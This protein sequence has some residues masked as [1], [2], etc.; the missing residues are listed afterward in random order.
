MKSAKITKIEII[1]IEIKLNEP[2]VI[3]K[4]A[5]THARNTV[6]KIYSDTGHYG[7]GECCPYRSIHGETQTGT[8]AFAKELAK[9]LIG[10]NPR[11]IHRH[12]ALMDKL[13]VGNASVKCAFDMALYDLVS[14]MDELPLYAFLK[15]DRDKKIYTDNT[16]SLLSKEKMV[17]KA[18]KF[19]EMGFPVLKV[20][21]GERGVTKDVERMQ[22]IRAA[23]GDELPLRID[24]NQGW[25]YLDAKRTVEAMKDLNIEHCEEPVL[26]GNTVDQVRLTAESPIPIMA[27]ESVFNHKDAYKILSQQAAHLINIKLGKS[28]GICNAMKIAAIAQAADVYCQTGSFSESRLGISALVHFDMAWDNIIFHDLDSPLMLSE[29]PVMGG[30]EYHKDW[31]VTV[32]DAHGHGADFDPVFLKRFENIVIN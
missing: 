2:F 1:P 26:A 8:V 24:A 7:V 18:I 14:K 28:G 25:N 5:L 16:V 10:S 27:D 9:I 12:V 11:E 32:S 15:G 30:M 29:D 19:K 20:K 22:A 3:S 21:L 4:G 17:E 31:E 6:I 23:V 13:I